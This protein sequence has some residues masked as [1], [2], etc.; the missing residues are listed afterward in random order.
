MISYSVFTYEF[1]PPVGLVTIVESGGAIRHVFFGDGNDRLYFSETGSRMFFGGDK[2]GAEK[3]GFWV[4]R[5]ETG[6]LAEAAGQLG[7]YLEGAR[8]AFDLPLNY[9]NPHSDITV[10]LFTDRALREVAAIPAGQTRSY[11]EVA[12]ACGAPRAARAVGSACAKNPIPYF[13][14]CHRV[15]GQNGQLTGYAGGIEIKEHLLQLEQVYYA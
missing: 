11:G 8:A 5:K 4:D 1:E 2:T 6:L 10:T 15:I 14:P 3:L 9:M 7:Q 12:A 13:I